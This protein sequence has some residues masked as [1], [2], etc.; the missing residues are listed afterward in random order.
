MSGKENVYQNSA[1]RMATKAKQAIVMYSVHA[2]VNVP[3]EY[4]VPRENI[5]RGVAQSTSKRTTCPVSDEL[6][7]LKNLRIIARHLS[8]WTR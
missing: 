3:S 8:I 2:I 6:P 7:H 1:A 5:S 4:I